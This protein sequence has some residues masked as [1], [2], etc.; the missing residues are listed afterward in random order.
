MVN[1]KEI[2]KYIFGESK[3]IEKTKFSDSFLKQII[4]SDIVDFKLNINSLGNLYIWED[5]I[6]KNGTWKNGIWKNGI[7]RLGVWKNGTWRNGI[8]ENG[9]WE[10]GAWNRGVWKNGKWSKGK[11]WSFKYH[12]YLDSEISPN[13]CEWSSSYGKK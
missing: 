9:T 6:W 12:E 8:W 4:N 5:G 13:K 10:D 7:W 3:I 2:V 11:I 1:N